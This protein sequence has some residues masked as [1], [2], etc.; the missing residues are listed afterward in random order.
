MALPSNEKLSRLGEP[1]VQ[2]IKRLHSLERKLQRELAF[3]QEY[4][5]VIKEYLD[6]GHMSELPQ[7]QQSPKGYYLPHHGVIK[8]TSDTTKFR[9]VSDGSATTNS[10][11]SLND[12]LHTGPKIQ[13]DLHHILLTFR[14]H[15][16]VLMGDIEKMY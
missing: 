4:H 9:A 6:F 8:V 2:A 16:Y 1:K 13:D 10:G 12:A 7:E 14:I 15:R 5:A 11:I 3:K